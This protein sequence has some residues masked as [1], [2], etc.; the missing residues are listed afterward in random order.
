MGGLHATQS[1]VVV[2]DAMG[3][4]YRH[5]N[6]VSNVLVP[7]LRSRGCTRDEAEILQAYRRCTLGEIST[8]EVWESLGVGGAASDADYC[9][10]HELTPGALPVLRQL[11]EAGVTLLALTN[12]ASSW[13]ARLRERFAL[14]DYVTRWFVSSEIGARKPDPAAY[15]AVLDHP[16]VEPARTTLVDDRATNLV[17]ARTAGFQP[18]LFHSED[19]HAHPVS[20]FEAP[21]ART[22]TELLALIHRH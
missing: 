12:D 9:R 7:Y 2:L 8:D 5:G 3:V 19:T 15:Q 22:M 6:V 21:E 4:L 11:Q 17:A 18:I 1:Q 16:G 20:G 10:H 13:S 14:G